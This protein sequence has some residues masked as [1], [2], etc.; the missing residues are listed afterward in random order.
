MRTCGGTKL[1]RA[2]LNAPELALIQSTSSLRKPNK[3]TNILGLDRWSRP[4]MVRAFVQLESNTLVFGAT[5]K[6]EITT[7]STS[8]GKWQASG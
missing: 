6:I 3:T 7:G 2:G 1:S 8:G 5:L 4:G